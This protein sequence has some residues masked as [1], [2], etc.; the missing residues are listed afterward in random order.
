MRRTIGVLLLWGVGLSSAVAD[1]SQFRGPGGL[2]VS[3]QRGVPV[4]W[5]EDQNIGW[6]TPLP[7]LGSSSPIVVDGRIYLTCYSGYGVQPNEGN[8]RDLVRHVVCLRRE[9]GRIVWVEDFRPVLP[10]SEYSGGNRSKHGYSS[11]TVAGDGQRLYVFFGKSGVYALDLDGTTLWHADVGDDTHG[12]GS[13]ASPVV[14]ENLVIVNA[15]VES[16]SLVAFDKATGT[17]VWRADGMERSWN[18]PLLVPLAD[19]RTE[20]VV[21]IQGYLLGFDPATGER[22]WRCEGIPTYVCPS[23]VAHDA[24]VYATGG[25]GKQFMI[26]VRAGGR[27]DVTQTHQLWRAGKGSNVS[28]PVYHDGYIYCVNDSRGIAYCFDATDGRIVYQERLRPRPRFM[29]ASPVLAGGKLYYV[30]QDRGTYVVA[31]RPEFELLARNTF[32]EGSSRT[33][34]SPA[35]DD[36][37]LLIRDD[38]FL[39]CVGRK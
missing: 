25:R 19:G 24:V 4:H 31:A 28:S 6:K 34:A 7:G 10:E 26:A 30:S 9:G 17:E 38:R 16:E 14:F 3:R 13:A 29:Y 2:G 39:Y 8:M 22:L 35:V 32:G 27:G 5:S 18:T 33:N 36:G 1:W 21:S 12:W 15:S 20:L 11:S 23:A 37:Q